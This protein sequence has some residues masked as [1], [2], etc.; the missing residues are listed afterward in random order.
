MLRRLFLGIAIL[1]AGNCNVGYSDILASWTFE[2]SIPTTSGPHTA[3]SG[4]NALTSFASSNT[5][6]TFSNPSGNGSIR[7]FSS[8]GWNAGEY[9]QFISSTVGFTGVTLTWDQTGS[10]TGPRDFQLSYGTDGV[11]FTN[12]TTSYSLP[13][14]VAVGWNPTTAN[15]SLSTSFN[16][17]LS[18][19]TTLD[20]SAQVFFR[21]AQVGTTSIN[22][23]T[24]AATGT[25][26]VDNFVINATAVPEPTSMALI[27]MVGVAGLAVRY[28]RKNAS[29]SDAV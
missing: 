11:T 8:N 2:T 21:L 26:R 23:A 4:V 3:E 16:A 13:G 12:F 6:G 25:G 28:R 24:V 5:G 29:S 15:A 19:F 20:N 1:L 14:P 27:G 22:A 7:S 17:D 9:F 10:N 18:A